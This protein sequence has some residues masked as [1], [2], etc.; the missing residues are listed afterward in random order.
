MTTYNILKLLVLT[1]LL[2]G[3][4]PHFAGAQSLAE[5]LQI[6]VKNDPQLKAQMYEY[7]AALEKTAQVGVLPEPEFAMG[8]FLLPVE[9]R[10]GPQRVRM[11]A[12]QML[13][14]MGSLDAQKDAVNEQAKV[15]LQQVAVSQNQLLYNI[16]TLYY[17][18][19]EMQKRVNIL[20]ENTA[21]LQTFEQLALIKFEAGM[22]SMVNV[23][24]TQMEMKKLQNDIASIKDKMAVKTI[25][26]NRHLY[27][28]LTD[29]IVIPKELP[30][31]Q[32]PQLKE[33]LIAAI[34]AEN[35]SLQMLQMQQAA[36]EKRKT[37]SAFSSKPTF[38][39]GLEYAMV[40]KRN[41][42]DVAKNGRDILMPKASVKIPLYKAKYQAQIKEQ[43]YQLL[44]VQEKENYLQHQLL[45]ALEQAYI[46]Y[47]EA[48]KRIILYQE[49][50]VLAKTGLDIL[51]TDYSTAG[52]DFEDVLQMQEQ[53]IAYK[54][55]IVNALNDQW[56]IVAFVESLYMPG[57]EN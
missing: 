51:V 34:A 20:E 14:W 37:A 30:T 23:I 13:P 27:R 19:Y 7:Q 43:D 55:A 26:I 15:K 33:N 42:M 17:E 28:N 46:E 22:S 21:I 38:G 44:A 53:I 39:V 6:A 32:L 8:V 47:E 10:V 2:L 35:P 57:G 31:P 29:E 41:D 56:Q 16:K 9:T 50:I 3:G 45:A 12:S 48:Q 40:T 1:A 11:S 25:K 52:K 5:L 4:N 49:Q 24:R 36:I 18:L 54:I